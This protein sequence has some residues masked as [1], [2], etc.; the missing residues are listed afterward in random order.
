MDNLYFTDDYD[1]EFQTDEHVNDGTQQLW[2]INAIL[3]INNSWRW[4]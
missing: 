4:E 3:P 1:D 2:N